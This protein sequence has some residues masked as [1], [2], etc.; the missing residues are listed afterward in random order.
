MALRGTRIS[1]DILPEVP[2]GLRA[3]VA[4]SHLNKYLE[5]KRARV[6]NQDVAPLPPFSL[7]SLDEAHRLYGAA[8]GFDDKICIVGAGAAGLYV[9]MM[10]KYLGITNVDILEASD[11]AGGRCATYTFTDSTP[12]THNYY[13]MGA[14]RIPDIPAMASTLNLINNPKLLNIPDKLVDYVYRVLD[15]K[16]NGYEP[17]SFWYSNTKAPDGSA[18]EA[19]IAAVLTQFTTQTDQYYADGN[20]NYSTRDYLM[21]KA[22]LTYEQTMSGETSDTST[23]LFD[24]ALTETLC[25]YSD[26]NAATKKPWYRLEGGMSVVTDTM[27]S[28]IEGS[29][30]PDTTTPSIKVTCSTPVVAMGL[31][32]D[33]TAI[34]VTTADQNG[35]PQP[36]TQYGMVFNTTAMAPLQ[37]MDIQ[38]LGLDDGIL[39][40]IRA[41]SYDRAT[42]VAIKF[43]TRWWARFYQGN[44]KYGGVSSSDLPISNVVYPSWDDGADSANVLMVSY[45][46][47]QDA[48]R[49]AALV[50]DYTKVAPQQS[51]A[52]VAVCLRGL[53]KLW[54]GQPEPPSFDDLWRDYAAHHAWAWSHDPFTGGAFALFGPGQF[55]NLY[56]PF[57]AMFCG[58]KFT[59]CGEALSAHHAWISGALD[60]AYG[61]VLRWLLS[62]DM[63]VEAA[64]LKLSPFGLGKGAHAEEI[65]ETLVHWTV[66]LSGK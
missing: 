44:D 6:K 32:P 12:C 41:L 46:W 19:A 50:P 52:I 37:R 61:A 38:G 16:G 25:D 18:F 53:V 10:L 8:G 15:A 33:G 66:K 43:K 51:D 34:E 65:D 21:L 35:T 60:S 56:P 5:E 40:G 13:D 36:P 4:K 31:S 29:S 49:M 64:K 3:A 14:M 48:S 24:Q 27:R 7:P 22:G 45:S 55:G 57:Q 20:D 62:R 2:P 63:F 17:T 9:A 39:T 26:F 58:D 23:G 1:A 28:T 47:A 59:M 30:W 54:A 42:K 11:H